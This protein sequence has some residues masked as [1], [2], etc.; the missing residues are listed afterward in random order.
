MNNLIKEI[1][2]RETNYLDDSDITRIQKL[3]FNSDIEAIL[4]HNLLTDPSAHPIISLFAV[5]NDMAIGHIVFTKATFLNDPN[6]SPLMHILA[7]LAV[8]PDYQKKGIGELLIREGI[9]RLHKLGSEIVFVLGH[10]E[11]YPKFGFI[12]NAQKL[13]FP[14]PYEIPMEVADAWMAAEIKKGA[15]N[16][17]RGKISCCK[18]M[19]KQEYWQE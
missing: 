5:I 9:S 11:Y 12:K 17:Y 7:P 8:I 13:G 4:T 18:A 16:K 15:L 3:A 14:A 10:I 6:S 1:T 2:I 19:D